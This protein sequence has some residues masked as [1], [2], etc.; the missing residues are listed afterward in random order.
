MPS[1]VLSSRDLS[2][3]AK[4]L[5][6]SSLVDAITTGAESPLMLSLLAIGGLNTVISLFYYLRVVKVMVISPVPEGQPDEEISVS[7]NAGLLL[8]VVA[9]VLVL[10]GIWWDRSFTLA[11]VAVSTLLK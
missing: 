11:E 7:F 8:L 6:F 5:V 3:F 1:T 2:A 4:F 10:V 9:M